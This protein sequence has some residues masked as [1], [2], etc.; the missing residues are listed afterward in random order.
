MGIGAFRTRNR[1]GPR[2][3][4]LYDFL[5]Q[6]ADSWI[7]WVYT[8]SA[9]R[10]GEQGLNTLADLGDR[11]II[12]AFCDS[13]GR[14]TKLSSPRLIAVYGAELAIAELKRRLTCRKLWRSAAG[15]SDCVLGAVEE[16]WVDSDALWRSLLR[17]HVTIATTIAVSTMALPINSHARV[18]CRACV[19]RG[20]TRQVP[21]LI[22]LC[23]LGRFHVVTPG[24]GRVTLNVQYPFHRQ[25]IPSR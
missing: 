23:I 10:M 22:G 19:R 6:R 2:S 21:S 25:Q 11:H 4:P 8:A 17:R 12:F 16:R 1:A 24:G 3:R 20:L 13:C 15:D 14:S 18:P 5:A 7:L 9:K